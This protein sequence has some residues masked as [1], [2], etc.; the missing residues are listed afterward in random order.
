MTG[1]DKDRTEIDSLL[2]LAFRY[3]NNAVL[4]LFLANYAKLGPK[5]GLLAEQRALFAA[6]FSK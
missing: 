3:A 6:T 1:T 4:C 5:Y 2:L